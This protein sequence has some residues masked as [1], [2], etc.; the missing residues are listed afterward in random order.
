MQN[1][2][3]KMKRCSLGPGNQLPSK[4]RVFERASR[5]AKRPVGFALTGKL[6]HDVLFITINRSVRYYQVLQQ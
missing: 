3:E 2:R 5:D 6:Q 4:E 1:M